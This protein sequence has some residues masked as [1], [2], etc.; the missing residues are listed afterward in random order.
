MEETIK[1]KI[2]DFLKNLDTEV[3][4]LYYVDIDNIDLEDSFQSIYSMIEDNQGFDSEII[5]YSRAIE[6]LQE[7]DPSLR[8]SLEI[9][10]EYG[11]EVSNLNSEILASLLASQN[12]REDFY[13]LED[14]ITEFFDEIREEIENLEELEE[15]E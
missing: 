15:D 10:S 2:E 7:N 12:I 4:V 8:N 6:Y 9:A 1:N 14:E 5:Y 3:E 13:K 11:Y